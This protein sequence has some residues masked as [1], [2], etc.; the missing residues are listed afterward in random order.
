MLSAIDNT[1]FDRSAIGP[2]LTGIEKKFDNASLLDA[3]IKQSAAWLI[4]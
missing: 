2:D 1:R 4:L 3:I